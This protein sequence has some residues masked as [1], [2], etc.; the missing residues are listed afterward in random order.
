MDQFDRTGTTTLGQS[1]PGINGNEGALH[2][3]KTS[4]NGASPSNVITRIPLFEVL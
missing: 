1:E 3:P 2:N 4:R